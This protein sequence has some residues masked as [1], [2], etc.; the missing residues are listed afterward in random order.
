MKYILSAI[1]ILF[2]TVATAQNH[3]LVKLWQTDS[4]FKVPESVLFDAKSNVLYVSNIDGKEPWGKDGVGSI[5]KLNT[6]GVAINNKTDFIV[7]CWSGIIYYVSA[8]GTKQVLMDGRNE[9]VNSADIG[10]DA[11]TNTIFV[12]TFW[13]NSIA[14]YRVN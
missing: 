8:N 12:P 5:G 13:R 7:S 11:V 2:I 10:F 14:A 9:K 4:V 1:A 6:D 3:S